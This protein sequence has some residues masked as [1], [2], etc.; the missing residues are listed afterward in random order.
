MPLLIQVHEESILAAG[1]QAGLAQLL[2]EQ[3]PCRKDKA[4]IVKYCGL[5]QQRRR[6]IQMDIVYLRRPG[7]KA[8]YSREKK[9]QQGN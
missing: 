3:R 7:K 5:T 8:V 9:A 6:Q 1:I 2:M 4:G